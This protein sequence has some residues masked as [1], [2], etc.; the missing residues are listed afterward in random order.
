MKI[1]S[2]SR[3]ISVMLIT[4]IML[5]PSILLADSM[6]IN[7]GHVHYDEDVWSSLSPI[8]A[9][10][11]LKQANIRRAMVSATPTDGAEQMYR[12]DPDLVIPMLRPYH[13]WRHRYFWFKDPGLREYLL[14]HLARV[15]YK[16]FGEFHIFADDVQ[17]APVA[18][19]IAIARERKLAL[20]PHTDI[21]GMQNF[22]KQ[23]PDLAIIWAH[24]GF[25][26]PLGELRKLLD[27]YPK[28]YLELSLREGM[29]ED[30]ELLTTEWRDFLI[31]YQ[32]RILVGSDTYKPPRWAE[33][34]EIVDD[35]RS[36]LTQLPDEAA[37]NISVNNINRLF[38]EAE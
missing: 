35:M 25:K 31:N 28:L 26:V 33:L 5:M 8:E 29:L 2:V 17:S 16:G 21:K 24:A 7:D 15:P 22:L 3:K 13:S 6:S 37:E 9:V 4:T 36:W 12:A 11:L 27:E 20:H 30:G 19:M 14:S 18:E 38:P 32:Q 34:S 10:D 1:Q 23:A